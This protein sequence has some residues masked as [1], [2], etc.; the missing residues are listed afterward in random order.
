MPA[1]ST[2]GEPLFAGKV[3]AAAGVASAKSASSSAARKCFSSTGR[4]EADRRRA[5]RTGRRL[6]RHLRLGAVEDFR[7]DRR[8]EGA[9]QR[10][11]LLHRVVVIAAR[12]VDA[13]LRALE[14]VLKRQ[15]V[16][17]RL[18]VRIVLLKALQRDDR[19]AETGL[20]ILVRLNLGRVAEVIGAELNAGRAG[21]RL[22]HLNEDGLF[23]G[24]VALHGRDQ[25]RDEVG[26][27]LIIGLEVAPFGFDVLVSGGDAVQAAPREAERGK[28]Y[29]QTQT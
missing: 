26:A 15:E 27:P 6:E 9:D 20:R 17:V 5:L 10:I 12:R 7:A 8:R 16:L 14:L 2:T 3:C 29:K 21:A 28:R 13:V 22:R 23:L 24:G 11:I 25:V 19:A 4:V 18:Q 1:W